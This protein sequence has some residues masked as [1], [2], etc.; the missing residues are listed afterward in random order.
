MLR[1][2]LAAAGKRIPFV[3]VDKAFPMAHHAGGRIYPLARRAFRPAAVIRTLP[4]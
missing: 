3:A 4:A 1:S 2:L